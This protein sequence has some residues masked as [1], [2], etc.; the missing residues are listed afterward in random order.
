MNCPH[1][2]DIEMVDDWYD[3]EP[4]GGYYVGGHCSNCGA[5]YS[6]SVTGQGTVEPDFETSDIVEALDP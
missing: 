2:V 3:P 4:D 1:C 6:L 5:T